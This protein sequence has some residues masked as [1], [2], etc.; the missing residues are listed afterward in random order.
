MTQE[1]YKKILSRLAELIKGTRFEGHVYAVGGCVRDSILGR[2]IK[3]IDLV[4]DLEGGGIALSATLYANNYLTHQPIMYETYG[5]TMFRL[6]DYPDYELEAVQT[7]KE[8]YH[9]DSRNPETTFGTLQEDAMRRDLTVNALYYNITTGE[10]YDPTSGQEDIKRNIIRVTSTPDIVYEDDPLRILRAIRFYGQF[11]TGVR[12]PGNIWMIDKATFEGMKS[13]SHRLTIISKERIAAE[14][15]KM[16]LTQYPSEC[17]ELLRETGAMHYVIPELEQTYDMT[18]NA[19][20]FGTVWEHTLKVVD[21]A[22]TKT[23]DINIMMAALLHDIGKIK[24]RTVKDD[25]VHFYEHERA[26]ENMIPDILRA[27]KEPVDMINEI[28]MLAGAHMLTKAWKDDLT[29]VKKIDRSVRKLQYRFGKVGLDK[30]LIL[31]DADNMAHAEGHCLPYQARL[32]REV[33]DRLVAEDADMFDYRLPVDGNDVMEV[34]NIKPSKDVRLCMQYLIKLAYNR[35]RMTREECL[36]E[37]KSW[38][39]TPGK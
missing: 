32:I 38:N 22:S 12:D 24:T 3:D 30:L 7:R 39:P 26:S 25:V 33:S 9:S 20:H 5:T 1:V 14:F 29:G 31:I 4:V 37:I 8:Q 13:H 6:A 15:H 11:N 21:N 10:F 19:Y 34:R 27:L 17:L 18:Q 16:L 35:P 23:K 28:K 2:E 36:R